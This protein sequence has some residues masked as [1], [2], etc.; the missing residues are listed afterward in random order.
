MGSSYIE[1]EKSKSYCLLGTLR[2]RE[3]CDFFCHF[4]IS[5]H[6]EESGLLSASP[7]SPV[8]E[9]SLLL[10]ISNTS[11]EVA[12][13]SAGKEKGDNSSGLSKLLFS[14]FHLGKY[15]KDMPGEK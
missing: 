8:A 4:L 7:L 2:G 10:S 3:W 12:Q 6:S 5:S 1:P 11:S 14:F 13:V 9:A 15:L